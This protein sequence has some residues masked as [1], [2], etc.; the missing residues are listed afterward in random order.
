M[1]PYDPQLLSLIAGVQTAK[2]C[3][4]CRNAISLDDGF[5]LSERVCRTCLGRREPRGGVRTWLRRH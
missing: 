3:R 2:S 1:H 4:L 5:G